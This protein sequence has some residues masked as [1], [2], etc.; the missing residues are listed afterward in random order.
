MEALSHLGVCLSSSPLLNPRK[1]P[2]PQLHRHSSSS[3]TTTCFASKW[4][5]RLIS[6]FQ[7]LPSNNTDHQNPLSSATATLVP[8]PLSPP[9]RFLS[10]PI[11]FYQILGAEP[12]FLSDGIKRAY[13]ARVSKPPQYGFSQDVLIGRRHILQAACETL[14]NGKS[15]IEYNQGLSE[16][17]TGTILT[18]VPWDKVNF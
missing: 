10:I 17:E 18:Q 7:F 12:H 2:L 13:E 11:D 9:D 15:R 6:D 1:P 3:T 4:A 16:D 8:P 14:S 5:E